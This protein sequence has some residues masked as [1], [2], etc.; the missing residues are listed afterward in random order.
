VLVCR[1]LPDDS[2]LADLLCVAEEAVQRPYN[3]RDALNL[4]VLVG[5]ESL[6]RA[7][8]L[9]GVPCLL[10]NGPFTMPDLLD[11]TEQAEMNSPAGQ[12][13]DLDDP[14]AVA[15]LRARGIPVTGIQSFAHDQTPSPS[16]PPP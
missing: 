13:P 15:T 2:V 6:D 4:Y 14:G 3:R 10:D 7:G 5:A 9:D 11:L 1:N 12:A 8:V 16:A